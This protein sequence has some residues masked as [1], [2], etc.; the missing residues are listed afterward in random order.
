MNRYEDQMKKLKSRMKSCR[1]CT[2][3]DKD[4][5]SILCGHPLPCPHHTILMEFDEL[6]DFLEE[7]MNKWD[8]MDQID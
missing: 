7:L 5:P 4:V 2:C 1:L 8:Q 6:D 3:P